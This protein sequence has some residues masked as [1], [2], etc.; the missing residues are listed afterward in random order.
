MSESSDEEK[1][2]IK[3]LSNYGGFTPESQ[4]W[5]DLEDMGEKELLKRKIIKIKVYTGKYNG[6]D[7]IFGIS[8]TFKNLSNGAIEEID[9]KGSKDFEDVKE[10][11]IGGQF[12]TDFHIRFN[13]E[14]EYISQ[15]GYGT[16]KDQF[17]VPEKSD[18]GEDKT[19][20]TNGGDN[21]IVGT[22]GYLK[23]KLDATGIL[24]IPKKEYMKIS[25]FRFFMLKYLVKKDAQFKD[26]WDK[27]YTSLP[28]DF[29][30]IWKFANLPDACFFG[31]IK[32]CFS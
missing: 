17:L 20:K 13:N 22:F 5:D 6:K 31:I 8:V 3:Y 4:F 28:E 1:S 15:L 29:Q 7:A 9:H 14:A 18:D 16:T 25:L 23:E 11:V 30:Y 19:I 2:L 32:F 10:F 27:Q 26:K 12:L 24:Y 21:I